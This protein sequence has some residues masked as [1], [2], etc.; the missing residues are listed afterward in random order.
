MANIKNNSFME[1]LLNIFNPIKGD[2]T[3][4]TPSIEGVNQETG[5]APL[6]PDMGYWRGYNEHTDYNILDIIKEINDK[7]HLQ[8]IF[9]EY[10]DDEGIMQGYAKYESLAD[11][12]AKYRDGREY[13]DIDARGAAGRIHD[14]KVDIRQEHLRKMIENILSEQIFEGWRHGDWDKGTEIGYPL[15]VKDSRNR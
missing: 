9:G 4:R 14:F 3:S 2:L 1:T 15:P 12:M 8:H 10:L 6:G 7:Q 13:N 5:I 11:M